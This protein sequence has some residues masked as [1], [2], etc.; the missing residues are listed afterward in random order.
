MDEFIE[1]SELIGQGTAQSVRLLLLGA[2]DWINRAKRL[3]LM[4]AWAV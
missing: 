1:F 2:N 4:I 3:Q